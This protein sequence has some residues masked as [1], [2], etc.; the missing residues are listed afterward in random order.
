[1][2]NIADLIGTP[3]EFGGRGPNAYDCYGLI[4]KLLKDDGIDIPDYV[5]PTTY[6]KRAALMAIEISK[7]EQIEESPGAMVFIK[8]GRMFHV[9]YVLKHGKFIH[10]WEKSG[11]VVIERLDVWRDKISGFYKYVE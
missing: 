7:W 1:M 11:G 9:G 8:A 4:M 3:F 5:C 2:D 6:G 10:C